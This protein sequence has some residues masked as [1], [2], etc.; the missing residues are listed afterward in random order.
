MN[1]T[2]LTSTSNQYVGMSDVEEARRYAESFGGATGLGDFLY[3]DPD[4][5]AALD[6]LR[7][8]R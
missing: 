5:A 6:Q 7:G 1:Q 8:T 3:D 2:S 4:G